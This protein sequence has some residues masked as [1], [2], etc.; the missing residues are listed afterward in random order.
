MRLCFAGNPG[1]IHTQRWV[2]HFA[3]VGHE[4]HLVN[5]GPQPARKFDWPGPQHHNLPAPPRIPIP[6]ARGI[7]MLNARRRAL[8]GLLQQIQPDVLHA[9]SV[10]DPGWL[11]ALSGFHPFVLT[12]W[13]SDVLLGLRQGPRLHRWLTRNA[14]RHAD[15]LTADARAVLDAAR[16][17]LRSGARVEL[18]RF[19]IDTRTFSPGLDTTWRERLDLE[20]GPVLL[21]IRQCHP[22]YNIDVI[23]RAFARVREEFPAARLLIKLVSQTSADPYL[24]ELRALAD[25]LA[26]SDVVA[27]VPQTSY[28]ELPDLYRTADVVLSVP[29]SDGLPVSVLEAMA[30]GAPVIASDLPALRELTDDGADLS[31]VPVR[32]VD[33]LS[34]AIMAILADPLRRARVIEENLAA[35]RR[36]A[37]FAVEMARMEHL[38]H[39]FD[40]PSGSRDT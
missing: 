11:A 5:L 21:S 38:Y 30:C 23:I 24:A 34:R 33:A 28:A 12:A 36:T 6:G 14:L 2:G 4:T 22:L 16:P 37:D 27:Y 15:L 3:E 26:L 35:V 20:S 1:S 13:G 7:V 25:R 19:G 39:S 40:H 9:H 29:S 18:I 17:C 31:L 32:D 10:A 8:S